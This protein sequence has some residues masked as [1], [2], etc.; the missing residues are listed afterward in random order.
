MKVP[1]PD[2]HRALE[3]KI[4]KLAVQVEKICQVLG[5]DAFLPDKLVI[6]NLSVN[7]INF[8]L[9]SLTVQEV[10]GALNVGI[11]HGISLSQRKD[12]ADCRGS[13]GNGVNKKESLEQNHNSAAN[14]K[15]LERS[16]PQCRIN[17]A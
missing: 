3:E 6:E 11:T 17:F 16:S 2:T 4:D 12:K 13:A 7:E 5:G 15:A 14:T 1:G 9:D 10:S 8:H